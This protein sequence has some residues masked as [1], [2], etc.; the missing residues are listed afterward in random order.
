MIMDISAKQQQCGESYILYA[1]YSVQNIAKN[2]RSIRKFIQ[3]CKLIIIISNSFKLHQVEMLNCSQ[4]Y[5]L[6]YVNVALHS[7]VSGGF[8]QVNG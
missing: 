3:I 4:L 6:S 7:S 5:K 2:I 1:V 8:N